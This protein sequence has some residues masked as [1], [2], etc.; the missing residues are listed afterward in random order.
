M[1]GTRSWR[2]F[3]PSCRQVPMQAAASAQE[4]WVPLA[5]LQKKV[6]LQAHYKDAEAV[7]LT[8][9]GL[10]TC[11]QQPEAILRMPRV[12]CLSII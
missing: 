7:R 9:A 10:L 4:A 11:S 5:R 8:N 3:K 6:T 2:R 1:Q 12:M